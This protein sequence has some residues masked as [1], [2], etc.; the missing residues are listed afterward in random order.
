MNCNGRDANAEQ[1][2]AGMAWV[3]DKYAKDQG[4]RAD[5]DK[6]KA[7]KIGLWREASPV[8]PWDWRN[9]HQATNFRFNSLT[10]N[11]AN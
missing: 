5:Q 6:A 2:R 11:A 3:Y 8:A 1:V 4:L 10:L 9:R 7:A